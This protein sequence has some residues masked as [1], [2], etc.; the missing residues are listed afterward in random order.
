MRRRGGGGMRKV[1]KGREEK[2]GGGREW[3]ERGRVERRWMC[4]CGE[5]WE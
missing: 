5:E 1:K 2:N 4:V 3:G